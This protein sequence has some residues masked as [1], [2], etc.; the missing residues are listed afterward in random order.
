MPRRRRKRRGRLTAGWIFMDDQAIDPDKNERF[1]WRKSLTYLSRYLR[2]YFT[3][4]DE[5]MSMLCWALGQDTQ[6]IFR[7]LLDRFDGE[8]KAEFDEELSEIGSDVEEHADVLTRML[9]HARKTNCRFKQFVFDLLDQRYKKLSYRGMS[10]IEKNIS[11]IAKMFRLNQSETAFCMFYLIAANYSHAESFFVDHLDCD[12]FPGRKHL[13]NILDL[14]QK[15]I[16]GIFSGTLE[17]SGL[18]EIDR[19]NVE[20]SDDLLCWLMN[21]SDKEFSK[22]FYSRITRKTVPLA[23][24]FVGQECTDHILR[25]LKEKKETSTHILLYGPPGTGKSSF[26]YGLTKKIGPDT[27][28]IVMGKEN[29]SEKRRAAIVA[30]LN[31][32]NIEEGSII[33]VDEADNILNTQFSWFMRGET[34]DKGWLNQL[35]EEPGARIIW[36]TNSI[37]NIEDSVLRRFAFS[38]HFKPFNRRQRVQLWDQVLRQNRCRRY[39]NNVEIDRFVKKH[40]VSAGAIDLVV[41]K[42]MEVSPGSKEQL[43]KSVSLALETHAMLMNSGEKQVNKDRI[44]KNY[45]LEGLN[46]KGDLTAIID[47]LKMFDRSLRSADRSQILNMNLLLY[48]PPGTGKSEFARYLAGELNR[49]ILCKRI[50]DLQSKWVGEG[51]KNIKYAFVEA[52]AEEAVLVIDEA[53]SLLFSRDRAQHSWEISFT[54]EF[55]TQMERFRGILVCTTNRMKDLDD[56]SIRRFN[57]K[58][59]FDYLTGAGNIVFYERL[60]ATLVPVI[61]DPKVLTKL[62]SIKNLAPGDFKIVRDRYSFYPN[63]EIN[64]RTLVEALEEEARIKQVHQGRTI[65][66]FLSQSDTICR[67][68]TIQN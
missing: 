49:E 57:H 6:L 25:L 4:D 11:T 40:N 30:C 59:G 53:D 55:L 1:V 13:K 64:H 9:M 63:A 43:H 37:D 65:V 36:V 38:L 54:N 68:D 24:H 17:K 42:A 52:E 21:P 20:F 27:Y 50:S 26:A 22:Q 47:Q 34:Q 33:L 29:T 2:R 7:Y 39:F 5:T 41:K 18:I 51:E 23:Y 61:V 16:N 44:E 48:G 3:I 15:Q 45:S 58:I 46:I 56:A 8:E 32:T 10:D 28:E 19:Y 60:L 67:S 66:G 14:N 35:L 31:M 62:K 12:K